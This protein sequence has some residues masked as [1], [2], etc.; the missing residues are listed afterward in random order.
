MA[1]SAALVTVG[2]VVYVVIKSAVV[3]A[4]AVMI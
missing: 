2:V 3:S 1:D 4:A